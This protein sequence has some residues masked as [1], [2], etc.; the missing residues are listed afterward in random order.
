MV[1]KTNPYVSDSAIAFPHHESIFGHWP[2]Y[3]GILPLVWD[4]QCHQ[5]GSLI[6]T[7]VDSL[8]NCDALQ[9]EGPVGPVRNLLW[10]TTWN[11]PDKGLT[12]LKFSMMS[13]TTGMSDDRNTMGYSNESDWMPPTTWWSNTNMAKVLHERREAKDGIA[14]HCTNRKAT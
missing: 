6:S 13:T 12:K 5:E 14:L 10:L 7:R 9:S 8:L 11:T 3:H 2:W 1:G 4:H